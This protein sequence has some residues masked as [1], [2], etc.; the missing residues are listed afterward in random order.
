M[1]S[2]ITHRKGRTP[3]QVHRDVEDLKDDELGRYGFTG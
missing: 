2:F 1:E 3:R